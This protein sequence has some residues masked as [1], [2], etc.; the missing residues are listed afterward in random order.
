M[1]QKTEPAIG[2][3]SPPIFSILRPNAEKHVQIGKLR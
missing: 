3:I 1:N 2:L